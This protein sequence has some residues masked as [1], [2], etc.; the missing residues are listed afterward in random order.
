MRRNLAGEAAVWPGAH[1]LAISL[2]ALLGAFP[3]AAQSAPAVPLTVYG[4]LPS[5][6]DVALSPDGSRMAYVR[7]QG[8]LRVVFVATVADRK[9]IRWIKT[10][11]EKLRHLRWADNDNLMI[12]TSGTTSVAGFKDEWFLLRVY[13]VPQNQLRTLPGKVLGARN[14]DVN[15][16]VGSVMV[17]R[18]GGHTVLFV[19]GLYND[20]S[21][22]GIEVALFSCDLT[23]G[24]TTLVRIGSDDTSWLVDDQGKLAA[25][26][27]YDTPAQRWSIKL[28]LDGSPAGA[29]SGHTALDVPEVLGFGPTSDAVLVESTDTGA[30]LWRLLSRTDGKFSAMPDG[31]VFDYAV[32]DPLTGRMI[33]GENDTDL[34]EYRLLDSATDTRWKAVVQAFDGD[35]VTLVSHSSDF[36]KV[37]VLVQGPKYGYRYIL[38]DLSKNDVV[39]IGKVYDG[40]DSLLEVRRINYA[41]GDGLQI[42]AY[43]TLPRDRPPHHLPLIVLPHG[44]PVASDTAEFDWWSQALADQGY[45][46]LRP[47]YRGSDLNEKFI[48]AGYGQWG[49]KMQTDLSDGVHYLVKHGI[50]DPARVC[51]VGASYGGYAVLAGV[52]ID[53][54]VYRCAVSVAGISDLARFLEWHGRG[55]L[56]DTVLTRFWDRFWG[57]S[58]ASDPALDAISP[59]K[60]I[61][62]VT[63]PVL[64]IHGRDDTIVP[65]EQ[66]QIMYDALRKQKKDVELVTLEHEDHNLSHG[67][68]R[69]QML[70]AT[71]AFLR[72]HNPPD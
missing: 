37:V 63:V 29:V 57:V 58:S 60:H 11:E 30:R 21:D 15:T 25:E 34:P 36:S 17:R 43:L 38:I 69:T 46:V 16:V 65:Y 1:L 72:A 18:V 62:A 40:V 47:N 8:E 23:S 28:F 4:Q 61:D 50:A 45:A 56:D 3:S 9:M 32:L 35:S 64:L 22:N 26:Q 49:R 66:S 55:G 12:I 68:T 42:P 31:T 53:P 24:L 51:I 14:S 27:D 41:A 19:P 7:T 33:G 52:T 59:I 71:V 20:P 2:L 67:D 54:G 13:N 39:S 10:G 5:I 6:E 44:G 48:E 70:Q